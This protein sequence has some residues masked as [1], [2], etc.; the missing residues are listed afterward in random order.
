MS[1]VNMKKR[2]HW[3]LSIERL[4]SLRVVM[5]LMSCSRTFLRGQ[6]FAGFLN[7][8]P[9]SVLSSLLWQ[10]ELAEKP[11]TCYSR[12]CGQTGGLK[13]KYWLRESGRPSAARR[14]GQPALQPRWK[15][16]KS[17]PRPPH[18]RCWSPGRWSPC[19]TP[20]SS[21]PCQ[22]ER[23]RQDEGQDRTGV[24]TAPWDD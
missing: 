8:R 17:P 21:A 1:R 18:R 5:E 24:I 6:V 2:Q 16:R 11:Q 12:G 20:P 13:L 15:R 3:I 7:T 14:S 19:A 10:W 4:N 23:R 22:K 9:P